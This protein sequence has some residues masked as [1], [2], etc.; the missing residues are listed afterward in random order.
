[1]AGKHRDVPVFLGLLGL[2]LLAGSLGALFPP[3]AWYVSLGKA[4]WNPPSAVFAPAWITLYVLI[5]LAGQRAWR[6]R[7]Q[8]GVALAWRLWWVQWLLNALWTPLFFGA[9]APVIA[10]VDLLALIAVVVAF[11]ARAW[12][13][14]R[15]SSLL[16]LPYLAW[17][18][19]AAS[20]NAAIVALNP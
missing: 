16:F 20:L 7:N 13:G 9:H 12:R 4:P 3:D 6:E 10:L 11:I 18:V 8:A 1:M 15:A 2:N 19:F 17:L 14:A 5:A